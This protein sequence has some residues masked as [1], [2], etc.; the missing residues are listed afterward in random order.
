MTIGA[1]GSRGSI[2]WLIM[3]IQLCVSVWNNPGCLITMAGDL[4]SVLYFML[5]CWNCIIDKVCRLE[6]ICLFLCRLS[7]SLLARSDWKFSVSDKK[8][9]CKSLEIS[10]TIQICMQYCETNSDL[11]FASDIM[12]SEHPDYEPLTAH[13]SFPFYSR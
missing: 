6:I 9:C 7:F 1:L 8:L 10:I 13:D 2:H 12:L 11:Y 4:H 5:N 3:I